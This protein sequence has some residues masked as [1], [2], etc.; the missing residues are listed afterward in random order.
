MQTSVDIR[1][2]IRFPE[3]LSKL[4]DESPYRKNRRVICDKLA[5][6]T[7]ALSQYVNGH[8]L[9]R[10]EIM[11]D[12]ASFFG[13]TL[14]YLMLGKDVSRPAPSDESRSMQRY[15]DWALADVQA[16]V[17]QR[18]WLTTRVGQALAEHIDEAVD[19]V[20]GAY[21]GRAGML[22]TDEQLILEHYAKRTLMLTPHLTYDVI[23]V[24][25][26]EVTAG[27]FGHVVAENLMADPPRPYAIMVPQDLARGLTDSIHAFRRLLADELLVPQERLQH[28]EVRVTTAP[29]LV[30]SCFY[31]L[32]IEELRNHE[33]TL[34][35]A[36]HDFLT[37]DG[38]IC[39]SIH[40][41][42]EV[43]R[44]EILVVRQNVERARNIFQT[45][46]KQASPAGRR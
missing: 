16:K 18:A 33:P 20:T 17:G 11:V 30:G 31:E 1:P 23:A 21:A 26:E 40:D 39:Y 4:I 10:P 35:V 2:K 36:L 25:N 38:W 41:T 7:T 24:D 32:D 9:P 15:L 14:D 13:V 44:G 8:S 12:L 42:D 43:T 29:M 27:R 45:L 19:R 6:S 28:W 5:I 37:P 22:T 3:I 34:V 46:W